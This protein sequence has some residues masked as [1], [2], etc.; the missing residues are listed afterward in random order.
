MALR[1]RPTAE[2]PDPQRV[3]IMA[4]PPGGFPQSG[5]KFSAID[6]LAA[7]LHACI[8]SRGDHFRSDEQLEEQLEGAG[9][10]PVLI[11]SGSRAVRCRASW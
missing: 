4:N 1:P 2:D 6:E 11:G 8:Q 10:C 9:C 3:L 7:A 5:D